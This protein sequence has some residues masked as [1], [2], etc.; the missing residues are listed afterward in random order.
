MRHALRVLPSLKRLDL[1]LPLRLD[2]RVLGRETASHDLDFELHRTKLVDQL[3]PLRLVRLRL[4]MRSAHGLAQV[5]AQAL[6]HALQPQNLVLEHLATSSGP[7]PHR[8]VPGL[9][10][11]RPHRD[12]LRHLALEVRLRLGNASRAVRHP[13]KQLAA[14]KASLRIVAKEL[15]RFYKDVV[16]QCRRFLSRMCHRHLCRMHARPHLDELSNLRRPLDQLARRVLIVCILR[17]H[18]GRHVGKVKVRTL[19]GW[20]LVSSTSELQVSQAASRRRHHANA[21]IV[22]CALDGGCKGV[23]R[24]RL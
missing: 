14:G 3:P 23:V 2:D 6:R 19:H 10:D 11:P 18:R 4:E 20:L 16:G 24:R 1:L 5:P 22:V 15:V 13:Q 17:Q 9:A 21:R 7:P 8:A 12:K